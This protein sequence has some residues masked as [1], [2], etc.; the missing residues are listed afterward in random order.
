ML[1]HQL[2]GGESSRF[3]EIDQ[4]ISKQLALEDSTKEISEGDDNTSADVSPTNLTRNSL[5]LK[6]CNSFNSDILDNVNEQL[7]PSNDRVVSKI[8]KRLSADSKLIGKTFL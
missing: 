2:R 7:S 4:I 5:T 3:S 8:E 6:H 1:V